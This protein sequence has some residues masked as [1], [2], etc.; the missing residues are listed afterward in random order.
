MPIKLNISPRIVPSIATLYNDTNRIFMEYVDNSIDSAEDFFN[1]AT[2]SYS[3]SIN[4]VVN[5]GEDFVS[6]SDNC[7]GISNFNKVVEQ[8]GNSDKKEQPWTNGQ[9]GYGIY[10]FMAACENLTIESKHGNEL[11]KKITVDRKKFQADHQ[12][13]VVFPDPDIVPHTLE[14]GTKVILK[15]FDR[16]MWKKVSINDLKDEIEKHFELLLARKNLR[17]S[18]VDVGANQIYDCAPFDYSVYDGEIYEEQL[19]ELDFEHGRRSK[20]SAKLIVKNPIRIFLKVTKDRVINKPPVFI[21]KGRRIGEIRDIKQ[22]KSKRKSDIWG[23]PNMTG[24]VDLADFLEPTIAR[25][26]F[27]STLKSIALFQNLEKLEPLILD[28]IKEVNKQS[29][30]QHYKYLENELTKALSKLAKIDML[31]FRKEFVLGGGVALN[32]NGIGQSMEEGFGAKDKAEKETS[33]GEGWG[34]LEVGDGIGPS[35]NSGDDLPGDLGEG[36][37]PS[38]KEADNPFL[39]SGFTGTER[40]RS[41]FDI[42]FVEGL[43][44]DEDTNEPIRSQLVGGSIRIFREHPDFIKRIDIKRTGEHKISQR[45]ITYL[46]GE[47]TVHYKDI[48]QTRM[49]QHEYSKKLF[50]NLVSFIYQFEEAI[51]GLNGKNLSE[52]S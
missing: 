29:E 46:A 23:H 20:K 45:L 10:S 22:F 28:V 12:D 50:E 32:P 41:G 37:S 3:K 49:G 35:G 14:S 51:S 1:S 6:I 17:I 2:N 5:V 21:I 7:T 8:I 31:N 16:D 39:D 4:I 52:M 24:Y 30:N 27:K 36:S 19:N 34:G 43:N 9:F 11:C 25:T 42:Q 48:M 47:I 26:D 33:S 40:K 13:D 18:I 44:I 38:N 15:K